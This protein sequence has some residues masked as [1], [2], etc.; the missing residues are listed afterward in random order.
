[1]EKCYK[2]R[3]YPTPNQV[4]LLQ[5]TFGCSRFVYNYYLNLRQ[6]LYENEG[7][8]LNYSACS[9]NMTQLKKE[10]TWLCEVDSTALQAS[11]RDLDN[12][13]QHFF[14]RVKQGEAPGFPHFKSKHHSRKSYKS[15]ANGKNIEVIE[16]TIKLPK[17]GFVPCR[18]SK[19]LEGRILSAT[20]SQ[21]PSGKYFVSV[22]CT[23]AE[24]SLLE[25]TG[26]MIGID[27]GNCPVA[28]TSDGG[29]VAAAQHYHQM[30]RKLARL[31][32]QLSRKATDG[33]NREKA[34]IRLA[35]LHERIANQRND[36]IHKHT[37][38]L[39]RQY[40]VLVVPVISLREKLQDTK[41]AKTL[42]DAAWGEF[43]HQLEY[44]CAWYG[45]QFLRVDSTETD[46][47]PSVA[48]ANDILQQGLR[49][50]A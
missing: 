11:L 15:K 24:I 31:Q 12:A 35:R 36:T 10:L 2:F 49:L 34:R 44:K 22:C 1:M 30:E 29:I 45:K 41:L 33:A 39:V 20:V 46:E 4:N 40:D 9:A 38:T 32:K 6:E 42:Q 48:A 27:V 7:V 8:T 25:K 5:R 3:I 23:E 18:V 37:T 13:Y 28:V 43:L 50:L 16:N 21:T 14:R 19:V 47:L 17:L 26:A